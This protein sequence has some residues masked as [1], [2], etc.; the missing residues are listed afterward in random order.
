VGEL[1][2][3]AALL[4]IVTDRLTPSRSSIAF[5]RTSDSDI[6]FLRHLY[7]TTR[8]EEL[9]LVP[10]TADQKASFLDMQFQAQKA[11]YDRHYPDG[12]FQVIEL[13]GRPIGRLYVDREIDDIR[14][15]DIA[16]LPGF[17]GRGIG[18]MLME[19]ILAEGRESRR[20]VT[21]HVEHNNPA[22]R[23]YERLGFRPIDD[24][25]VYLFME[26]SGSDTSQLPTSNSQGES[27]ES[28]G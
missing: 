7:G 1:A 8:E 17:Q 23:L 4:S 10:W 19:E 6:P 14:I 21:I 2:F 24:R 27:V 5:R 18:R 28:S 15:V 12:S 26:W 9:R 16:L 11:H 13:E 25:G 3:P 20:R 22:L